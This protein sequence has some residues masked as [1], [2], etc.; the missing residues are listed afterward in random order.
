MRAALGFVE[1]VTN[2]TLRD[3]IRS[4]DVLDQCALVARCVLCFDATLGRVYATCHESARQRW[5]GAKEVGAPPPNASIVPTARLPGSALRPP[6]P[7][8]FGCLS[9]GNGRPRN[10]TQPQPKHFLY[11]TSLCSPAALHSPSDDSSSKCC[12]SGTSVLAQIAPE[13]ATAGRPIPGKVLS[14]HA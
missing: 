11:P 14:P 4:S 1:T 10:Y 2:G 3:L 9:R 6:A 8:F 13:A 5:R 7:I 12:D